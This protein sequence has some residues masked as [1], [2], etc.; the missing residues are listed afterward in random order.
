M[1]QAGGSTGNMSNRE[2]YLT[3]VF[4]E[5]PYGGNRLATITNAEG[6]STQEMQA[7]ALA[8]NFAET[9]FICGGNAAEGFD[10]RI[11]TPAVEIPFAGH[12]TLGTAFLLREVLNRSHARILDLNL[13][14]GKIPVTF[15]ADGIL[16][17]RQNQP[18]FGRQLETDVVS[19]ELGID[20]GLLDHN[21]PCQFVST[22]LEFLLVP[23]SSSLALKEI[24]IG[25]NNLAPS[26]LLFCRGGYETG[27]AV[28]ARMFAAEFGVSED[29]ATGSAN[30]CLAAYLVEHQYFGGE[31]VEIRVGQGYEIQRPSQLYLDAAKTEAGNF[32][33]NVGGKVNLVASGEWLL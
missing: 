26:I 4:A 18:E 16:W 11:F 23:V 12:P 30:G 27:Q 20:P 7:I 1:A 9:T 22:G 29:P 25:I 33:I 10:V 5:N 32:E 2:Y 31:K 21:F 15:G 13:T 8:F 19:A 24:S 17:M 28:S 14:V 3:E 6:L